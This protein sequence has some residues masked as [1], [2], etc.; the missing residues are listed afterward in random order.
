MPAQSTSFPDVAGTIAI[1]GDLRVARLGFGAM[2]ITGQGVWGDPPDRKAAIAL[3]RHV[4]A[5][6]VNFIDTADSY[7]PGTSEDLIAEAL[8]PYPSGLVITTKGGYRRPGPG[9][10]EADGAPASLRAA[11]HASL[12]RLKLS[13]IDLY[14]LHGVDSKVPLAESMGA[15]VDLQKEGKIRHIGISNVSLAQLSEARALATVVSVQ[16]RYNVEDRA[17][18]GVLDAASKD[19]LAF[20]PWRPLGAGN[21]SNP[22]SKIHEVAKRHGATPLQVGLAWLL[23]RA[24]LMLPIPGTSSI[25]HLEDN[26]S[27]AALRLT[28]EDMAALSAAPPKP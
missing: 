16:N 20:L 4:V 9:V 26:L 8:H 10:W 21:L 22:A 5:R 27:A 12:K 24:P 28:G 14:Q 2:R 11:C 19:G 25:K 17:F 18:D 1:G 3:L 13:R 6:G 15:L 7:G 23:K